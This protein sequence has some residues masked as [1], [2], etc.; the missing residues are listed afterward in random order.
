MTRPMRCWTVAGCLGKQ[1]YRE[2]MASDVSTW[3]ESRLTP[4]WVIVL[5]VRRSA[6]VTLVCSL[7]RA[8][9]GTEAAGGTRDCASCIILTQFPIGPRE[10]G[11]R[12]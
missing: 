10:T 4:L 7:Q 9:R 1:S 12:V 2:V 8:P 3:C 5:R 6:A 11:R